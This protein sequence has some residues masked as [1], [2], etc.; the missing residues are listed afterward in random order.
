MGQGEARPA[1]NG[2]AL[3][4][5]RNAALAHVWGSHRAGLDGPAALLRSLELATASPALARLAAHPVQT[6]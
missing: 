3:A 4:K 1:G 5:G 2:P 6:R